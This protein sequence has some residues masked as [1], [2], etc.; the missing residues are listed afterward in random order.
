MKKVYILSS[1]EENSTR[2]VVREFTRILQQDLGDV[3]EVET[4]HYKD[5]IYTVG[6]TC[7][8]VHK[9]T[10]S[11]LLEADLV[12][13]KSFARYREQAAALATLLAYSNVKFVC[14]EL[15]HNISTTKLTEYMTL[16]TNGIRIPKTMYL[17]RSALVDSYEDLVVSLG[18]KIIVK[19]TNGRIGKDNYLISSK[20]QLRV[21]LETSTDVQ[22]VCQ[23]FIPN[24]YDLRVLIVGKQQPLI[25]KRQRTNQETHLNNTSQGAEATLVSVTAD[26]AHDVELSFKAAEVMHRE[27]AGVDIMH[28]DVT[29][30]SYVIEV[31]AGPQIATGAFV[32]EKRHMFA[33]MIKELLI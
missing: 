3:A 29:G 8:V 10:D 1:A 23:E 16:W 6:D 28:N 25:I 4:V 27:F 24:S 15:L 30:E 18:D 21:A 11:N 17:D 13:F 7:S 19:A 33:E 32:Q 9:K 5:L 14:S 26:T 31:N 12:Y 20:D 2:E 22:F